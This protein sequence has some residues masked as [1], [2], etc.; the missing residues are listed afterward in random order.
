[1]NPA[2]DFLNYSPEDV[3]TMGREMN[4]EPEALAS[5]LLKHRANVESYGRET[6]GD[7]EKFWKGAVQL[8]KD[9]D[10]ALEK[11]RINAERQAL[12]KALPDQA[13]HVNLAKQ[14]E[15]GGYDPTQVDEKYHPALEEMKKVRES[16]AYQ[17]PQRI[18]GGAIKVGE[19]PL[20]RYALREGSDG[21]MDV[22]L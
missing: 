10:A 18:Y 8:D 15:A 21:Q 4:L 17:M 13:D 19:T 9:T 6:A 14:L 1:M 5:G 11:V 12:T 3:L 20:A 2:P 16:A 7:P 22:S